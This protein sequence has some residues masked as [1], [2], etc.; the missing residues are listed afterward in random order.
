MGKFKETKLYKWFDNFWYHYK[1][2]SIIAAVFIIFFAVSSVQLATKTNY[3][4][5]VLYAGPSVISRTDINN[6][7]VAFENFPDHDFNGDGKTEVCIRDLTIMSQAEM[8]KEIDA[9]RTEDVPNEG[10]NTNKAIVSAQMSETLK[11]FDQEIM[12]GDSVI[13]L[14]SPYVYSTLPKTDGVSDA[15]LP[16]SEILGYTP[17]KN[18]DECAVYLKSTD[19]GKLPGLAELPDDTLLCI[20]RISSM[21]F[22]KGQSKTERHHAHHA[23]VFREIFAYKLADT[24]NNVIIP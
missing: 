15:F 18:Y 1:W 9:V 8:D 13:C 24:Q 16:L 7:T 10:F 3:D 4:V 17:E 11:T 14:L 22:L 2:I 23:E 21:S 19:F 5:Y 20:R 6:I 12:G